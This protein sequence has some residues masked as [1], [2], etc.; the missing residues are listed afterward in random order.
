[1]KNLTFNNSLYFLLLILFSGS[2]LT[3]TGQ[4]AE[5]LINKEYNI[6]QGFTLGIDNEYGEINIVNWNQDRVAVEIS[7]TVEA[8]SESKA[9]EILKQIEI[10]ISE[11]KTAVY[12]DTEVEQINVTGKTKINVKYDVKAPAYINAVLEQSYGNVYIQELTGTAELE[13][14][15]GNLTATSLVNRQAEGWNTLDLK[16]GNASIENVSALSAEIK[17]SELAV[18]ESRML[19]TESAYSKLNFGKVSRLNA[20]CKYDKLNMDLLEGT[21]E[22]DGAYTNVTVGTISN[23]FSEVFVDLAYGN[24][25]AG[26]ESQAAFAIEADIS[27]GSVQ[28]PDGDYQVEKEAAS[29]SVWGRVGGK[30]DAKILADIKYG[31]LVLE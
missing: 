6:S 31:N 10:D 9:E 3:V 29:E 28:I 14:R 27:Y 25:K 11:S 16:Y 30:S 2:V 18:S 12:F 20:E 21:L 26:L 5:K 22:V 1:M 7:I 13:I 17:Y 19:E 15:Y 24:F 23:G 4:P 8:K